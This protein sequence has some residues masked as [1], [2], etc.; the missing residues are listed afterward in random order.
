MIRFYL[1][2]PK[3]FVRLIFLDGFC[4]VHLLFVRMGKFKLLA[5]FPVDH[6]A[7]PVVSSLILSLHKFTAFA[8]YVIDR[9]VSVIT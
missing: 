7:Y 5:Q 3:K 8:Y 2:I 9:F 1:K 4:V 6:L